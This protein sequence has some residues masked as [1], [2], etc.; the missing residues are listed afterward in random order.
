MYTFRPV[1]ATHEAFARVSSSFT[2]R[3]FYPEY[4]HQLGSDT[5][6]KSRLFFLIAA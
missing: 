4:L 6:G 2:S 3:R 1:R 5:C